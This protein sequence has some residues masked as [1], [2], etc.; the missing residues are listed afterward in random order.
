ME[1]DVI[2]KAS[3]INGEMLVNYCKI[4]ERESKCNDC[5]WVKSFGSCIIKDIVPQLKI[6]KL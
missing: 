2:I 5:F 1:K 3:R 4:G 6:E